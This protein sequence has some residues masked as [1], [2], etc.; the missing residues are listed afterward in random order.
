LIPSL[1][2]GRDIRVATSGTY[3]VPVTG[4]I[5]SPNAVSVKTDNICD[6][7]Q[8]IATGDFF[9]LSS[10]RYYPLVPFFSG[11]PCCRLKK[12]FSS[13]HLPSGLG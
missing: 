8:V 3:K 12:H 11:T 5:L 6:P 2:R 4:V 1:I 7:L 13:A 10:Y 9:K